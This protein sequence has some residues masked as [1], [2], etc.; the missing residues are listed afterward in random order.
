MMKTKNSYAVEIRNRFEQLQNLNP[1]NFSTNDICE[2]I[3][4]AHAET[5]AKYVLKKSNQKE[6]CHGKTMRFAKSEMS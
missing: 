4:K 3:I 2:S 1:D 6:I 5:A